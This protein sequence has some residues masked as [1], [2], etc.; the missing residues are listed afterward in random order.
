MTEL[1]TL[2]DLNKI[3]Y[4]EKEGIV[5]EWNMFPAVPLFELKETAIKW[6]KHWLELDTPMK[7]FTAWRMFFNITEEDLK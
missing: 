5:K 7:D 3:D 4:S 2:K 1:K 6:V